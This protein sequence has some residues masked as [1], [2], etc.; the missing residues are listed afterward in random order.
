MKRETKIC[1]W[2]L[3]NGDKINRET[4][5]Q[6]GQPTLTEDLCKAPVAMTFRVNDIELNFCEYHAGLVVAWIAK[7]L[8]I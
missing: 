8:G 7:G 5:L 3:A 4:I 1:G 6:P 2:V